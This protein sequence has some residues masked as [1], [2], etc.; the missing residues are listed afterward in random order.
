MKRERENVKKKGEETDLKKYKNM[1]VKELGKAL[2]QACED[3]KTTVVKALLENDVDVNYTDGEPEMRKG[4]VRVRTIIK[5]GDSEVEVAYL[6]ERGDGQA[7]KAYDIVIDDVSMARNYR[8]EFYR[9]MKD[10][11]FSR[12]LGK[13]EERTREKEKDF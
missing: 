5:K 12:L 2:L 8:R 1:D 4:K 7:W 11:G 10:K 3:G 13:I 6:L 9:I